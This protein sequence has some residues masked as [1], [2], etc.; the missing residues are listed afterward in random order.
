M[1]EKPLSTFCQGKSGGMRAGDGVNA[2]A[3]P[4]AD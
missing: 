2:A 1:G 4:T 3:L